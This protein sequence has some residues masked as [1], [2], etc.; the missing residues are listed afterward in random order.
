[1]RVD[2]SERELI[3]K[4]IS[5]YL[6]R[7]ETKE[8]L[9]FV[10]VGSVDDG[11][12]TLIGRLLHDTHGI[13]E[14]QL[15]A[16]RRASKQEGSE[17]DFSLFTD[18]LKA[19]R[20]Q[21]ITIDV[22]YRYFST[23][24]R[25]FIIADTPGHVQ[26]TRNMATGASTA[27]LAVILIDARLGVLQ[28][29]R[30]HAF[31]AALLGIPHL[32]VCVNKM[33]LVDYRRSVF[34]QI[35]ESFLSFADGLG[36]EGITFIP[37]SALVGDN[38]VERS[39]R[40]AWYVGPT[41]LEHLETVP[42]A[43]DE[44]DG[45]LRYPVQ[46][47][48][49]PHL[50][51]RGFAGQIAAG[52]LRA[53][54]TLLA[55]PSG[56]QSRVVGID[57]WEGELEEAR[58]PMCV[59]VRLADE[60]DISRGD[61]LVHP[62]AAPRPTRRFEAMLVWMSERSLDLRRSYVL[63]HTTQ[64]VRAEID[65]VGYTVDLETLEQRPASHL[66]L[67][68]IGRVTV[69]AHRPLFVDA[70][71]DSRATGAFVLIDALTNDTVAAGMIVTDEPEAHEPEARG[72]LPTGR[73][74]AE[75]RQQR[76]G[77]R[78]GVVWLTGLPAAG[79]SAIAYALERELFDHGHVAVVVDPDDGATLTPSVRGASPPHAPE[80]AQRLADAGLVAIFAFGS[81]RA[82]DRAAVRERV[83]TRRFVEVWVNTPTEVCR[84][85]DSRGSY[86]QSHGPL[87]H[88]A[89]EQADATVE[90]AGQDSEQIAG[91]LLNLL[92][93]RAFL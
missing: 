81:P 69:S 10:A 65:S 35:R 24:R 7:H 42:L 66:A 31:I 82:S 54:D 3:Q 79:K 90:S 57:T 93:T 19:E 50:G 43:S 55:L 77:Q 33:D 16:V 78:G 23:D 64:A 72:G 63:K 39:P 91:T 30:R 76:L 22:A 37:V 29:S 11:K 67:N 61:M 13:Y 15:S 5:A 48:L 4:D 38:V 14:D 46:T 92:K 25:K 87:E 58:H 83:G 71:G 6:H 17:I 2:D 89:P 26:Y 9:R 18:G 1:M 49:R 27:D 32:V 52:T 86:D 40:L 88:E 51:Y 59:S 36:F 53:G 21:G 44:R 8:L 45:P 75:E 20:E 28:Q 60:I 41:V 47:V 80:L 56:K 12:S 74:S 34:N 85:R 73:V 62:E 84:Q 68:D 70:Y